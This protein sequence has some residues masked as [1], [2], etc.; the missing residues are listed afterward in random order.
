MLQIRQ[1][2]FAASIANLLLA[3][4]SAAKP[5]W[6][7]CGYDEINLDADRQQYNTFSSGGIVVQGKATFYPN[8]I[9]FQ[10]P[11]PIGGGSE[12]RYDWV[13]NRKTLSYIKI[14]MSKTFLW[15]WK[16]LDEKPDTGICK[17]IPNPNQGNKI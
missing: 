12:M 16:V 15:D 2:I 8:Q 13:I 9:N 1:V 3:V 14:T 5:I 11:Y 6:L 7:R 4:P 10:V 17:I